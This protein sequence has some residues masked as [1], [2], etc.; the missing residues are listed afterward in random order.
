MPTTEALIQPSYSLA[1][2]RYADLGVD[3]EAAML[4]G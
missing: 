3:T 4:A 1:K 2:E